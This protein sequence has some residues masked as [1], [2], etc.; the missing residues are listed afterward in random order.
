MKKIFIKDHENQCIRTFK[1]N[2]KTMTFIKT[3]TKQREKIKIIKFC[4]CDRKS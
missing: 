1:Q 4:C 3:M 2:E